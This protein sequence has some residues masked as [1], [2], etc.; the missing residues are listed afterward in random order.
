[1]RIGFVGAA[2]TGK[3]T[4][5]RCLEVIIPERLI[6]SVS[7]QVMMQEGLTEKSSAELSA[8]ERLALQIKIMEAKFKQDEETPAGIFDRTPIDHMAYLLIRCHTTLC[9]R[10][11]RNYLNLMTEHVRLYDLIFYFPIYP[12]IKYHDDGFRALGAGYRSMQ[13]YIMLGLLIN[14]RKKYTPVLMGTPE[15]RAHRI[16]RVIKDHTPQRM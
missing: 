6:P 16:L 4:T 1:M 13:D 11:Y 14:T 10:V 2:S 7:R 3:T 12:G 5:A 8:P 15:A 9:D